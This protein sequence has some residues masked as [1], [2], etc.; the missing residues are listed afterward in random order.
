MAM[1]CSRNSTCSVIGLCVDL[2]LAVTSRHRSA[3]MSRPDQ[4]RHKITPSGNDKFGPACINVENQAQATPIDF[5]SRCS[6]S[7]IALGREPYGT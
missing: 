7:R 6:K 4:K 3:S 2:P 5:F 1:K